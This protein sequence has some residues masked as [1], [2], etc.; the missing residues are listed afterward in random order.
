MSELGYL[1]ELKDTYK[2]AMVLVRKELK[3][4]EFI[5]D[6]DVAR[7]IGKWLTNKSPIER[8]IGY[9]R[10]TSYADYNKTSNDDIYY[11]YGYMLK[12]K[13]IVRARR[14]YVEKY[15]ILK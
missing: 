6:E 7:G 1:E 11:T 9:H 5:S 14:S 3:N 12:G 8:E 4:R 13:K 2:K 10:Y 15:E